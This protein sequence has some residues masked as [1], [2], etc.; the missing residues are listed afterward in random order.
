VCV[1]AFTKF[2]WLLPVRE[3]TSKVTIKVLKEHIF[4]SFS[5]PE[6]IV[7]DNAQ[8]FTLRDFQNFC[9]GMAIRHV[10]T[11]PY[12]PQLSHA[13]RFNK[14]LR[15]AL[16]AHHSN[17]QDTWDTQ[18]PWLQLAFN[19]AEHKSTKSSPFVVVFPFRAGSPLINKW[20]IQKMLPERG[21]PKL[22][23]IRWNN[24]RENLIKS[25]NTVE[26]RYNQNRRPSNFR[27]VIWCIIRTI[28]SV[29]PA[30]I[31]LLNSC[32]ASKDH[33]RFSLI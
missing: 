15:A 14:N 17:A 5:V 18:L 26:R 2:V 22:L 13:E 16:I 31:L 10:S 1:D 8:C 32:L 25:L 7:S 33:I 4:T 21:S 27:V 30:N 19:T 9:F 12:Y 6:T 29:V 28:P 11:S 3:A 20:K 23:R 24:V